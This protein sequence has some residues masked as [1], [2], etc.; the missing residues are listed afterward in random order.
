MVSGSPS[1][2]ISSTAPT[3]A[4]KCSTEDSGTAG[5]M[6]YK[7]VDLSR[8]NS[9]MFASS[10]K[11]DFAR[12]LASNTLLPREE[13][14]TRRVFDSPHFPPP[15]DGTGDTRSA[16][17]TKSHKRISL[18]SLLTLLN[19]SSWW[20]ANRNLRPQYRRNRHTVHA[21]WI[22]HCFHPMERVTVA[23]DLHP[24]ARC[25]RFFDTKVLVLL[26]V[27]PS[28]STKERVAPCGEDGL[29]FW[30]DGCRHVQS[31]YIGLKRRPGAR[32]SDLRI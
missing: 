30:R 9:R 31:Q 14:K 28:E 4:L 27:P 7:M 2:N 6:I 13:P 19:R 20:F 24:D 16:L 23:V 32:E 22:R 25:I 29:E 15:T 12:S 18:S 26:Y 17:N 11:G 21:F 1:Q 3:Q 10:K 8:E 5:D